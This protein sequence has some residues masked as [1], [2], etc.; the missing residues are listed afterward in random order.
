MEFLPSRL[1]PTTLASNPAEV[2]LRRGSVK[3]EWEG[4]KKRKVFL[5]HPP[6]SNSFTT[7]LKLATIPGSKREVNILSHSPE[8]TISSNAGTLRVLGIMLPTLKRKSNTDS[9][10]NSSTGRNVSSGNS[11]QLKK[12]TQVAVPNSGTYLW[13]KLALTFPLKLKRKRKDIK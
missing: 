4:W 7:P 5:P 11:Q 12:T 2:S 9:Y 3:R 13:E 6:T 1:S 10:R 8:V